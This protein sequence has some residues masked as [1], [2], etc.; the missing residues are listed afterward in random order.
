MWNRPPKRDY[1]ETGVTLYE[2]DNCTKHLR[3]YFGSTGRWYPIG[4]QVQGY[5]SRNHRHELELIQL[6]EED[7]VNIIDVNE[8]KRNTVLPKTGTIKI[9]R[10]SRD[11][12]VKWPGSRRII[13]DL[14]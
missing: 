9:G 5:S 7:W 2:V 6:D 11:Q 14:S 4:P 8:W 12:Y 13:N 1:S 10:H 3:E